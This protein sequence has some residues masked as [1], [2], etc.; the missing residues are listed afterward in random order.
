ME[1]LAKVVRVGAGTLD[2]QIVEQVLES[3]AED[4]RLG[5]ISLELHATNGLQ[6]AFHGACRSPKSVRICT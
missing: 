5:G 2:A 6:R 4:V 3:F 1:H